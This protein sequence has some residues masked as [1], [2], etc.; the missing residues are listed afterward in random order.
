MQRNSSEIEAAIDRAIAATEDL[1]GALHL[2][3]GLDW[4]GDAAVLHFSAWGRA[5][6][7]QRD[8][9]WAAIAQHDDG[10]ERLA[11]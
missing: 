4:D 6:E 7:A 10:P 11:A 8:L 9:V 5:I 2:A 1:M 3:S